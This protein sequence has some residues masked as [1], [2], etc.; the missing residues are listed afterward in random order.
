MIGVDSIRVPEEKAELRG[1]LEGVRVLDF[2]WSVAGPMATRLL[3]A[4]GAEI[5]KVEWPEKPDMM[6]F[7]LYPREVEEGFDNGGFFSHTSAGKRHITINARTERGREL[8]L[9][10]ISHCDVVVES[11]S[12]NVMENWELSFESMAEAKQ[13]IIYVSF[14]GF[15]HN[16]RYRDYTS[17]GPT[18][19]A[20]NGLTHMAGSPGMAP[21]GWGF[22]YMDSIG[23]Y[24]IALAILHALNTRHYCDDA[25]YIDIAQVEAG[26]PLTGAATLDYVTNGVSTRRSDFPP[27]NRATWPTGTRRN[28]FRGRVAAPQGIYRTH[29]GGHNDYIAISVES[30][31]EWMALVASMGDPDWATASRYK[32]LS[33][34]VEAQ[35]LLDNKLEQW[36][37]GFDKYDLMMRLQ[38]Q[39]VRAGAVQCAQELME[40]DPQLEHRALFQRLA[41]PLLGVRRYEGIPFQM[42]GTPVAL[43]SAGPL[44][45]QDNRSILTSLLGVADSDIG[46]LED[47][48]VIWR[49][50]RIPSPMEPSES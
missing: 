48:G 42:L 7:L 36:T 35:E 26:I 12:A 47:E 31:Q 40:R 22:S 11:F 19:Q 21:S 17:W 14:S 37:V 18:A 38:N 16:G 32:E 2:T 30:T 1:A 6:R 23:S 20:F 24:S 29:G 41:H 27:G 13:D 8:L 34:R 44:T 28:A 43:R 5:I 10:L 33:E 39:G 45:G 9:T 25:Q 46:R 4:M 3:A 50:G 49:T 15:G